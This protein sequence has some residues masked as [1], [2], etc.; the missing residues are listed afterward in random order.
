[1]SYLIL[2]IYVDAVIL[3]KIMTTLKRFGY[4]LMQVNLDVDLLMPTF[5]YFINVH[6]FKTITVQ[7]YM[8]VYH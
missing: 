1:M 7:T 3:V 2:G 8:Y 4:T 6:I 5:I